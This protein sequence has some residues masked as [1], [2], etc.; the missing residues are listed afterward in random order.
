MKGN[1]VC[2]NCCNCEDKEREVLCL[3]CGK[4]EMVW[5]EINPSTKKG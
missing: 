4:G 3:K 5:T 2:T 1:Y